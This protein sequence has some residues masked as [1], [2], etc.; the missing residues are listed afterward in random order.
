MKGGRRL[1]GGGGGKEG[2][3]EELE[4]T[5][6]CNEFGEECCYEYDDDVD[7]RIYSCCYEY[8]EQGGSFYHN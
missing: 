1:A 3:G 2:E 5:S 8:I 6:P 7:N 4:V